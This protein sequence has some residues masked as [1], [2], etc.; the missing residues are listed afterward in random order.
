MTQE[1][2]QQLLAWQ[3]QAKIDRIKNA[4]NPPNS[5]SDETLDQILELLGVPI[6]PPKPVSKEWVRSLQAELEQQKLVDFEY[7]K[8]RV[9]GNMF[10]AIAES[11][12]EV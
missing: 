4:V 5:L 6:E 9:A 10:D 8:D 1:L 7:L 3:R 11:F 12:L 2:S